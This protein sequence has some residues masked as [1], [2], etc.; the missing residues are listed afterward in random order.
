MFF[1]SI[2][3]FMVFFHDVKAMTFHLV[4][5]FYVLNKYF[6]ELNVI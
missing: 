1:L 6:G 4:N 5:L 3:C 2:D